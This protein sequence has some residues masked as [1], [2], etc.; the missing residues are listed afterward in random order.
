MPAMWPGGEG[1]ASLAGHQVLTLDKTAGVLPRRDVRHGDIARHRT[2][3]RNA[4]ADEHRHSGDNKT[5]NEAGIEEA[6][7]GDSA[8]DVDVADTARG[9]LG[10]DVGGMP[11]QSLCSCIV[12]NARNRK[13]TW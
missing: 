3:E 12:S 13:V 11:R 1:P 10:H 4:G 8:V 2:E 7:N 9:Q 5:L 6:L